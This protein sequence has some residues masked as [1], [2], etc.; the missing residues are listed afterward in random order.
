MVGFGTFPAGTGGE[1]TWMVSRLTSAGAV[2]TTFGQSGIQYQLTGTANNLNYATAIA[3]QSTGL[4]VF[5]VAGTQ[6]AR[7]VRLTAAG[8]LDTSFGGAGTGIN[9]QLSSAHG[10][11]W[12]KVLSDDTILAVGNAN[13]SGSNSYHKVLLA[14]FDST[15]NLVKSGFGGTNG[16]VSADPDPGFSLEGLSV[17]YDGTTSNGGSATIYIGASKK[18][19]DHNGQVQG[20]IYAFD[21]SG[22]IKKWGVKNK[23]YIELLQGPAQGVIALS[24][25]KILAANS[26]Q[27]NFTLY[28]FK[29][30]GTPDPAFYTIGTGGI[31]GGGMY[32][33][34][35]NYAMKL[36]VRTDN[37]DYVIAGTSD[38]SPTTYNMVVGEA[39]PSN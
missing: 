17:A 26:Y 9:T 5:T 7:L 38:S 16:F 11:A 14:K 27:G 22:N 23:G 28:R 19:V 36:L 24:T 34:D 2:D 33:A 21:T 39:K 37:G 13:A 15:G 18:D 20:R 10:F 6:G 25:G 12:L 4:T 31:A 30:D 8:A 35:P 1:S 29:P 3:A 32:R